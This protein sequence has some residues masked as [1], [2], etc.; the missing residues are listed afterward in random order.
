MMAANRRKLMLPQEMAQIGWYAARKRDDLELIPFSDTTPQEEFRGMLATA[1]GVA[2]WARRFAADDIGAAPLLQVVSRIGVGYDSVDVAT[3][4]R[5]R[6]P[7]LIGGTANSVTVAEHAIFFMLHLAKQGVA[8]DRFVRDDRWREKNSVTLFDLYEKTLLI[9]GFGKIGTRV[10]A[11]ALA[12][13][14]RVLAYDPFIPADTISAR[15]AIPATDLDAALAEAD[16]VTIHCPKKPDTI[17]LINA[18]R[19]ARMKKSAFLINTAR[20]GIID[21]PALFAALTA[22]KIA[23]AGLDVFETEPTP[24]DNPLLRAPNTIF[25]PHMAGVSR[26]SLD[27]MAV[28]AVRNALSVFDGKP[29]VENVVNKEVL[30]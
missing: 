4:T 3:L 17:G 28:T 24:A 7:L 8:M 27:R 18:A 2:L 6:I 12:L 26:E 1:D 22:G 25:A 16:F 11:R 23:G 5:R 15:G 30:A 14:M 20:G 21:E 29:N 19:L 9:V 13:E 10:A